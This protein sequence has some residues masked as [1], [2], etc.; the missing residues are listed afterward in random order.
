M[1]IKCD[2]E[3]SGSVAWELGLHV[4]VQFLS[5]EQILILKIISS[6]K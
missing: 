2:L 5:P 1:E 3:C 4:K 6:V